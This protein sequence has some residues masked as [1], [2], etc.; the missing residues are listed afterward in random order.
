MKTELKLGK[1]TQ[2]D[3]AVVVEIWHHGEFI[4]QV[5]GA[6]GPGVRVITKHNM[7]V[8]TIGP[9]QAIKMVEVKILHRN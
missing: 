6:D 2:V 1:H 7:Q 5:V 3:G 9:D 8:Q 4:G